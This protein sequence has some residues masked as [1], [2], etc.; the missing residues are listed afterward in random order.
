MKVKIENGKIKLKDDFTDVSL[1]SS[2][3]DPKDRK[4]LGYGIAIMV[5]GAAFGNMFLAGKMRSVMKVKV[6]PFSS[7]ANTHTSSQST[8][9]KTHQEYHDF[10]KEFNQQSSYHR[11]THKNV[12]KNIVVIPEYIKIHLSNLGLN[13]STFHTK[14][15]TL[16]TQNQ[17]K[18][19]YRAAVLKY[20]PDRF[21]TDD[22]LKK[23]NE[24]KFKSVSESY[25][26]VSEYFDDNK[27]N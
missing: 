13:L 5:L 18:D 24:N 2:T 1:T 21:P 16:I 25:K 26:T 10:E 8:S 11:N 20:H 22:P 17:I 3:Y 14:T 4:W 23:D 6:D 9:S 15:S 27:T 19:A 7:K 12:N